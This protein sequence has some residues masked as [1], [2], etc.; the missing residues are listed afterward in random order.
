MHST[1]PSKPEKVPLA[2][3]DSVHLVSPGGG[4]FGDPRHR[5]PAVLEGNLNLR[6]INRETAQSVYGAVIEHVEPVG[7][8]WHYRFG[9]TVD[10]RLLAGIRP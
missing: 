2:P 3:G 1:M 7:E 4:G 8:H 5:T 6:L 9:R 10:G